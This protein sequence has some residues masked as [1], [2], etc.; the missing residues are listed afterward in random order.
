MVV[1]WQFTAG[2]PSRWLTREFN[3]QRQFMSDANK[4]F[5]SFAEAH[6]HLSF[7]KEQFKLEERKKFYSTFSKK[8]NSKTKLQKSSKGQQLQLGGRRRNDEAFTRLKAI[9]EKGGDQDEVSEAI[10]E[11]KTFGWYSDPRLPPGWLKFNPIKMPIQ[12]LIFEPYCSRYLNKQ[13]ALTGL[14]SKMGEARSGVTKEF[15]VKFIL[16]NSEL[17]HR[18]G[19]ERDQDWESHSSVPPGWKIRK[20]GGGSSDSWAVEILSPQN[21]CFKDRLSALRLMKMSECRDLFDA[22]ELECLAG[23]LEHEGWQ[24]H[25][26]IPSG[27]KIN[28]TEAISRFLTSDCRVMKDQAAAR[29]FVM[30]PASKVT[31]QERKNFMDADTSLFFNSTPRVLSAPQLEN[32]PEFSSLRLPAGWRLERL[33]GKMVKIS[34]GDGTTTFYSRLQALE[35]LVE[36][37]E[38]DQDLLLGLWRSLDQEGWITD[39]TFVP[40]GWAVRRNAR[41]VLFLTSELVVLASVEEALEYIETEEEYEPLAYK[42]LNDWRDL[43]LAATWVEDVILPPGWLKTEVR[44]ETEE[45]E[46]QSE[47]F[48]APSGEIYSDKVAVIRDLIDKDGSTQD[49]LRLW[50]SLDTHSWMVDNTQVPLG[51]K[52]RFDCELNQDEYLSPRME[53]LKSRED[54]LKLGSSLS[55]SPEAGDRLMADYIEKWEKLTV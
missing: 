9:I 2:L 11:L 50:N 44:L 54:I 40:R 8:Q 22:A 45:E 42:V 51:W 21:I 53:V 5:K 6:Q 20:A 41:E 16:G 25:P 23:C 52:I 47:H 35:W 14:R 19:T 33:G 26:L 15:I 13:A 46:T 10:T 17:E 18:L 3:G 24:D 31:I 38:E 49:V 55:V 1:G 30:E 27:W 43:F 4:I 32:S 36:A 7:N 34:A 12:Y 29:S 37:G 39:L 28:R 48:L